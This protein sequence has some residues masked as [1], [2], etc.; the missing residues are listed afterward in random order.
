MSTATIKYYLR[1]GLLPPPTLK[2]GRNMA[3]YDRSFVDR[4]RV[5]KELQQKRFLPLEVIKA[6][7]DQ[8]D[9]VISPAEI[10][11]LLGLEGTFYEA[12]HYV[13]GRTPIGRDE[14]LGRSG[15]SAEEL[16]FCIRL[17]VL[18]PCIR[19]GHEVFEGDDLALLET[20]ASLQDAGF[21]RQRAS[22]F[23]TLPVYVEA[24]EKLAGAELKMFSRSTVGKVDDSRLP[25]M[26]M[27]GM[28]LV[29]QF[30]VLLRRKLLLEALR[31]LRESEATDQ[32]LPEAATG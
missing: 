20:F 23:S 21:D 32:P 1:E 7:L 26:A 31:V 22:L 15:L 8:N 27:A 10:D 4:L 29:E 24:L 9:A 3:Y 6:I 5:I 19:D 2:T 12:V 17:G 30:I 28:R 25:D 18:S 13:P 11:A 16:D 14:A